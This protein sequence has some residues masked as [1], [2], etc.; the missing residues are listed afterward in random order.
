MKPITTRKS[1]AYVQE[2][3]KKSIGEAA[4][5]TKSMK[6]KMSLALKSQ[7]SGDI[8]EITKEL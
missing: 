3:T 5:Q 6:S 7:L 1:G 2:H 8:T 4:Y